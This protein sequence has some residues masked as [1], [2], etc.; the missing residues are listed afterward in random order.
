MV[1]DERRQRQS[2]VPAGPER[3]VHRQVDQ[4]L[5]AKITQRPGPVTIFP[6]DAEPPNGQ[7]LDAREIEDGLAALRE[8][9]RRGKL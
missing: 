7:G 5:D 2:D 9:A 3:I 6:P 4:L 1:E 8:F